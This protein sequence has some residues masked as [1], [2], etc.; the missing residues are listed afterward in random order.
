MHPRLASPYRRTPA[1]GLLTSAALVTLALQTTARAQAPVVTP[2]HFANVEAPTWIGN[3]GPGSYSPTHRFLQIHDELQGSARTI[4][5]VSFRRDGSAGSGDTPRGGTM[6]VN[7]FASTAATT[8]AT[9]DATFDNNH[10]ADRTQV[11][12]SVVLRIP[13]TG[14]GFGPR[15]FDYRVPFAQPFAFGGNGPF[16]FEMQVT[17]NTQGTG[18]YFDAIDGSYPNPAPINWQ[19]GSGC[20]AATTQ[21][22]PMRLS[23][24]QTANWSTGSLR[25]Q[26]SG[27]VLPPNDLVFVV[28]GTQS[29][30][31]GG[32]PLPFE[33]P[34][35]AGAPSGACTLYHDLLVDLPQLTNGSGTLN[36]QV[37]LPLQPTVHGF[38]LYSQILALD[39]GANPYG[40]VTSNS[41]RTHFIA[42]T[43]TSPVGHVYI[44]SGL[45]ATGTARRNHGLVTK[46]E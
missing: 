3:V 15:G 19:I 18:P 21:T 1:T 23:V 16:C 10:G 33:L 22:Y 32:L 6:L 46:I 20:K 7:L 45:G 29:V 43:L 25:L 14:P 27:S 9:P 4:A 34:G 30:S 13:S 39:V 24:G 40:V 17:S 37:D 35:T 38:D 11:G 2:A 41:N 31:L 12:R 8:A 5:A 42:P 44:Q 28:F 26:L 36:S